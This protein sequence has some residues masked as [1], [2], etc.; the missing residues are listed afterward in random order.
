MVSGRRNRLAATATKLVR[1][2]LSTTVAP[3]T[4]EF[5]E[6]KVASGEAATIAEAVDRS[7]ALLKR[8]ENRERLA[9]ATASYFD[10]MKPRAAAEEHSL[11]H[12]L[13]SAATG[14]DF[15]QEL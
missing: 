10:H 6:H 11:A 9:L 2:K 15:D 14:I 1:T 13:A 8:L 12:D 5:L 7:I 3:E 4:M